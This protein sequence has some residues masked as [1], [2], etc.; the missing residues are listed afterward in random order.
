MTPMT[1]NMW[2]EIR[3]N[4]GRFIAIILIILLGTLIFVGIKATG[5]SLN[6]SMSKTVAVS[7]L[8]D[9][10][11][12]STTGFNREDVKTAEKVSGA[13][14]ET[15]KFKYVLGGKNEDVVALY[16]FNQSAKQNK[17]N[18][19]S[20]RLPKRANEIVLDQRAKTN[21]GYHLGNKYHFSKSAKLD[22]QTY[23]I[24]GFADSPQYIDNTSRGVANIGDGAVKYFAYIPS[25]QMNLSS[26][27]LLNIHFVKLQKE[28][29]YSK[30]YKTNV[31]AK[32]KKIKSVFRS[33][34]IERES[35]LLKN[36]TDPINDQQRKLDQA[37]AQLK[38]AKMKVAEQSHGTI[39]TTPEL[40]KQERILAENQSKLDQARHQAKVAVKTT[41]NWQVRNDLPGFA[42]YS[43]SSKR[44]A[45]IANVFPAFFFLVAALITFTTVSRMVAEARGQIGTF[46][47]LGYSKLAIAKNYIMYALMAA[48]VGSLLG[49]VVGNLTL[50]RLVI[51]LFNSSIPMIKVIPFMWGLSALAIIF[52]LLITVGAAGY[53]VTQELTEKPAELLRPRAPKAAKRI[54]LERFTPLWKRLNFNQKVSYRNLFRY[55]SRMVM[56]IIGIAGGTALLLTGFGLR[57][58]IG[59]TASKQYDQ[60]IRYNATVALTHEGKDAKARQVLTHTSFYHSAAEIHTTLGKIAGNGQQVNDVSL[61]TPLEPHNFNKYVTLSQKLPGQGIIISQKIA[62]QLGV[63]KGDKVSFTPTSGTMARIKVS[64]ITP[65]YIGVFAYMS[66]TAFR[67]TFGETPK[68][69]TLFVKLKSLRSNQQSRLAHSLITDGDAQGTSFVSDQVRNMKTVA[70]SLLP[71]VII[72][73]LLS[74]VLSFVV[75]YNLTNIN[76]SERLRELSTIKVLGFYDKEVTMY[77]IRE[78]VV[79]TVAGIVLGYGIGWGLLAFILKQAATSLVIFPLIIHWSSTLLSILLM[80]AFTLIIMALTHRR[81]KRINMV[82]AL[83]END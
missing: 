78:N 45:A 76:V 71:V 41:Y 20:G 42:S 79:L 56:T 38:Q 83:K 50:P 12:T 1:K 35:Q 28:N 37:M 64:A 10:Q 46:K 13:Q 5:P 68:V 33:R 32:L 58:S 47:A 61:Y 4:L 77:I 51:S 30:A 31:N 18:L 74:G 15:T 29:T 57:D 14:A 52:S 22:Q 21:Y 24:V 44:I 3:A 81:L 75:L 55:K 63:K 19:R 73:I 80:L 62:D 27:T 49:S 7:K 2:R 26:A 59:G 11:L 23:K 53:V 66:P 48:V 67:T 82:E 72:I 65:N 17:L 8:S 43:D 34:R 69:N 25:K 70:D 40:E 6:D 60:I 9:I 16:G 54:L 36:A 39:M